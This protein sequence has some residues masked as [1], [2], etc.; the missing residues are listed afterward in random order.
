MIRWRTANRQ[1]RDRADAH[2]SVEFYFRFLTTTVRTP[3]GRPRLPVTLL[4]VKST[5]FTGDAW[6]RIFCCVGFRRVD[7]AH[8]GAAADSPVSAK[9]VASLLEEHY[10]RAQSL[11]VV[12]MERY[13][14]GPREI[15]IESG[16]AYS[17]RSSRR[18]RWEYEVSPRRA[19]LFRGGW[20]DGVVLRSGGP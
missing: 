20:K 12:F 3:S 10:R 15:R 5:S 14:E 11:R 17:R 9:S 2:H 8:A 19:E 4:Y 7:D 16:T 6:L 18:M 1:Q 13:S